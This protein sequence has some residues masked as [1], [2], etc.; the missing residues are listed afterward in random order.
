MLND[1]IHWLTDLN[2]DRLL[3]ILFVLL[4][5]DVP[6]YAVPRVLMCLWDGACSLWHWGCG[7]AR[8]EAYTF[9]PSVCVLVPG[10]NEED[11]IEAT[12]RSMWGTYPRLEIIVIDDGSKDDTSG[13]AL[14]FARGHRGVLV[15]RR[16]HRGGKASALNFG[17]HHT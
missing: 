8:Q 12:L 6:R 16:P 15:L 9:C 10:Y 14:R 17:L 4:V 11:T 13:V 7:G 5:V 2:V 3:G 1:W